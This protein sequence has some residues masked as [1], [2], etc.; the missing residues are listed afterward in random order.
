MTL[1][2]D[3]GCTGNGQ[4]DLSKRAMIAVVTDDAGNVLVERPEAGGSNN[5]A[6]LLAIYEALLWCHR[7]DVHAVHIFTDSRNNLAWGNCKRPGLFLN[8]RARVLEL[9]A[10]IAKLRETVAYS[11]AWIPREQNKAG[12]VIEAQYAC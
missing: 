7:H 1:Y 4:R 12:H 5:V 3:G 10:G 11:L 2:V 6:E 9:Q 8:N